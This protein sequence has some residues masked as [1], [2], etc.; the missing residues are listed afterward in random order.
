MLDR[1][2]YSVSLRKKVFCSILLLLVPISVSISNLVFMIIFYNQLNEIYF[3]LISSYFPYL[4]DFSTPLTLITY[5]T[6]AY[7]NLPTAFF[8]WIIPLTN[9]HLLKY[10][11][12]SDDSEEQQEYFD[13][14]TKTSKYL[15][16]CIIDSESLL[17]RARRKLNLH[18]KRAVK[19]KKCKIKSYSSI[20]YT[21]SIF[22]SRAHASINLCFQRLLIVF[23]SLYQQFIH[24][25][26]LV[27]Y[28]PHFLF[29]DFLCIIDNHERGVF[30]LEIIRG[31]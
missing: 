2:W 28:L 17:T 16:G 6:Y 14:D 15:D 27:F 1:S 22:S 11:F 13:G 3:S 21:I 26:N 24:F 29:T 4:T 12:S 19:L 5:I 18:R 10:F 7:Y 20:F 23:G 31:F 8:I 9:R 30:W 25:F